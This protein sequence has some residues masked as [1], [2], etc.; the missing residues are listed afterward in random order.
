VVA[1]P[2]SEYLQLADDGSLL[3]RVHVHPGAGRSAVVGTHGDALRVKVA[4]PPQQGRA[5][6]ACVALVASSLGVRPADVEVVGGSAS[7]SKRLRVRGVEF[8]DARRLLAAL[9]GAEGATRGSGA[10]PGNAGPR[11]GVR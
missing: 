11:H 4:A 9:A 2:S 1:G 6:D 10:R 7:R 3:L 5:N 8:D